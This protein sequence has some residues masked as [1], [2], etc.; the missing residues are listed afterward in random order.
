MPD[1]AIIRDLAAA[2]QAQAQAQYTEAVSPARTAG[3]IR[4]GVIQSSAIVAGQTV[5][6]VRL[7]A[8]AGEESQTV[9]V[10]EPGDIIW[11][12]FRPARTCGYSTWAPACGN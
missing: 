1:G 7:Y 11:L 12:T 6:Q 10:T 4:Y 8:G 9:P 3:H 5:Y 2:Q